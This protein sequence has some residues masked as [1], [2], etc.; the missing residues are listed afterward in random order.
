MTGILR[1]TTEIEEIEGL[2][3]MGETEE[4][5]TMIEV[6]IDDKMIEGIEVDETETSESQDT[7][8]EDARTQ[9][10]HHEAL[11]TRKELLRKERASSVSNPPMGSLPTSEPQRTSFYST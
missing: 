3:T 6:G 7:R 11:S 1:N 5:E 4:E 10:R 2:L 9:T 8:S